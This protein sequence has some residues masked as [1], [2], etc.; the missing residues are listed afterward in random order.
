ME[1]TRAPALDGECLRNKSEIDNCLGY[2]L[3]KRFS[4]VMVDRLQAAR[5]QLINVY[6]T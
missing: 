6:E 4:Q 2:E 3:L 5:L 1:L